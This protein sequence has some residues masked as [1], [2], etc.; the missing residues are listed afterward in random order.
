MIQAL[1]NCSNANEA[2]SITI[3][4]SLSIYIYQQSQ[5]TP[6]NSS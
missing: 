1:Q 4:I 6:L 3:Y 2:R 5:I